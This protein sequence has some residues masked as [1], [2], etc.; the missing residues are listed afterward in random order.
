MEEEEKKERVDDEDDMNYNFDNLLI[1][2]EDN[3]EMFKLSAID[4]YDVN[5]VDANLVKSQNE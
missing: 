4:C 3:D 2:N 5:P 1:P